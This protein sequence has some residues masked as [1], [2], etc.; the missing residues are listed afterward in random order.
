[1]ATTVFDTLG[2]LTELVPAP[3]NTTAMAVQGTATNDSAAAGFVGEYLETRMATVA[4]TGTTFTASATVPVMTAAA[5]GLVA[6]Q[7]VTVSNSGGGLPTGLSATTNYYVLGG[8]A[9]TSG[10][11]QLASTLANAVA[12]TPIQPS[13]AGTGT[14]TVHGACYLATTVA[15][16]ICGLALTAGDWDVD[17]LVFPGYGASTSVTA[18]NLWI[19][20]V[21]ASAAPTTAANVL[22][23]GLSGSQ[24]A[25]ANTTNTTQCWTSAGTLR[26]SLASA[27]Y[28]ALAAVATFTV[29]TLQPQAL[30]RARRV[31]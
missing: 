29:S 6:L 13:G 12:G 22:L 19:A 23:Q 31:R 24:V 20:Q 2:V 5:H 28:L 27:G 8:A 3:G 16:D 11:F 30:L 10:T 25:T 15:S 17:A 4:A 21:G 18:Y 7:A 9:L 1:M 26:V 14:Q